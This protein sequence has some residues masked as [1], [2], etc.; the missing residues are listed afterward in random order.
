MLL[1][2]VLV[3]TGTVTSTDG[4]PVPDA[5]VVLHKA[6]AV[7]VV[8][9]DDAGTFA[10]PDEELPA[11]ISVQVPGFAPFH[12]RVTSQP[13]RIVLAPAAVQ[14]SVVV[15]GDPPI[16]STWREGLSGSTIIA[17]AD[18][19]EIPAVTPDDALRVVSGFSLF[20]RSSSRT[21]NPTT[22][23][24]TMRGLS[25][26][27]ASRGL[28]MVDG[29]PLN[30]GFG[31]WVTWSRLPMEAISS[32]EV[33]RGAGGDA[34]GSDALGGVIR[35][36]TNDRGP[37]TVG[38]EF[39]SR[40]LRGG[41]VSGGHQ[42]GPVSVFGAMS[43]LET[44]GAIPL[45]AASRGAVDQPS[46]SDWIN[47]FGRVAFSKSGR[48]LTVTGWGG[49]DDRGNGTVLQ[50]NRMKGGTMAVAYDAATAARVFAA[51]VSFSPNRFDQTFSSIA[52]SRATET[53]TNTQQTETDMTRAI[54]EF[55]HNIPRGYVM[56]RGSF[57]R[58]RADF[59]EIRASGTT[60]RPLVDN[61]EAGS[62][63]VTFAPA[64]RMTVTGGLRQEWRQAPNGGDDRKSAAVG[65]V[66]AAYAVTQTIAL[67]TSLATSHRWPTLNELVR[68]F[69]VGSVLTRANETLLPER[70]VAADASLAFTRA[71]WNASAGFFWTQIDDAI[72]NVTVQATPTIIRE[73]RNAGEA[74]ARGLEVEA[75]TKVTDRLR[76]RG[77]LNWADA[78]FLN[79][80][81]TA[82]EGNRLP[83]VPRVSGSLWAD[84]KLPR[85]ISTSLVWHGM[86][87]QFD[88]DR[89]QFELEPGGQFDVRVT[90]M[91]RRFRWLVTIENLF[92]NRVR[93]GGSCGLDLDAISSR[94]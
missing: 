6:A 72:A 59:T 25:A 49:D 58:G 40:A 92:D 10:F 22:H 29:V 2:L 43:W 47:L 83:Q 74:H 68:N 60:T 82:L 16:A 26:S 67:R 93:P 34:F 51:R 17:A 1:A 7:E 63:H 84:V 11:E 48:R 71:R 23:G 56:A 57:V 8:T 62:L 18:L 94:P 64:A 21:S 73:R 5:R 55:G 78:K 54:V 41:Q 77:S 44:D 31:G 76:V 53:L 80:L 52:A 37:V 91:M 70:A 89:N 9:T 75:E 28:V 79:S 3:I 66:Q 14:E 61:S 30:E 65:H 15:G 90:G 69:Q 35:L 85:S 42:R 4:V 33:D 88:D 32:I 20:R 45:E 12:Q 87:S 36:E 46:D 39:G 50:R 13:V 86:S 24:V 19:R 27:G 38:A 81:E